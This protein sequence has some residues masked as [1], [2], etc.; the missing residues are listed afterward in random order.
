MREAVGSRRRVSPGMRIIL[1]DLD[2]EGM[3]SI[4]ATE[5]RSPAAPSNHFPVNPRTGWNVLAGR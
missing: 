3:E 5:A 2:A 1:G 4:W